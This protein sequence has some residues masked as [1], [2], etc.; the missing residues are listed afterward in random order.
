M[1]VF[2]PH[3]EYTAFQDRWHKCRVALEGEDAVKAE[4]G[5]FLPRLTG[6]DEDEYSAYKR[7][8]QFFGAPDRTRIGLVG[9]IMWKDPA[10]NVPEALK[11]RLSSIGASNEPIKHVARN[12]VNQVVSVGRVG[13]LIDAPR[14]SDDLTSA[15]QPYIAVYTAENCISWREGIVNG[16]K[17]LTRVVLREVSVV[18]NPKDEFTLE[19]VV[20]Y[21][22]LNLDPV[23]EALPDG[24]EG[25]PEYVYYQDIWVKTKDD[26]GDEAWDIQQRIVPKRLGG[27]RFDSIPFRFVG[28]ASNDAKPEKPPILDLV[29]V[30]FS[31]YRTSADLEHGRHFTALPTAYAAGFGQKGELYIGSG[32]AWVAEDSNARAGFVEFTGAGLGHLAE[33]LKEKKREMAVLGARLLEEQRPGVE[34][35]EAIRLRQSGESSILASI[36]D[37]ASLAIEWALREILEWSLVQGEAKF[38]L[39]DDF[40]TSG[41]SGK[42]L[43]ALIEAYQSGLMSWQTLFFNMKR[44]DLIPE[45]RTAEE[46]VE[47][48]MSGGPGIPDVDR[49]RAAGGDEDDEE[50]D[51][52]ESPEERTERRTD[53]ANGDD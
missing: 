19:T 50:G 39:N 31:Y 22:V 33:G 35:A 6:Q 16:K 26:S 11:A 28:A 10:V 23:F 52:E 25:A 8:A 49:Q 4:G 45:G 37:S 43:V 29:E 38:K 24:S 1:P 47:L 53:F 27:R 15:P 48:I 44:G 41:L 42:D 30:A 14:G 13:I 17:Q 2:T 9:A 36:S 21:R 7:R 20:K 5:A 51:E 18:P 40:S 46:E 12:V 3:P 32:R 34:A